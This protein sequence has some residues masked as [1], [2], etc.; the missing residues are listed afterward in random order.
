MTG[1]RT[2]RLDDWV[3]ASGLARIDAQALVRHVLGLDR[4]QQAARPEQPVG[5]E[6]LARLDRLATRLREGEPLAYVVGS[7]EFYGLEFDVTPDV[8]IPRPET[9]L[10]VDLAIERLDALPHDRAARALDLGT[11]SGAIAI[12]LAVQRPAL[13]VWAVD[14]SA[15]ALA[16]AKTNALRLLDPARP[17]GP[18]RFVQSRWFDAL[19]RPGSGCPR[20]DCIASN[21]PYVA[22]HDPHLQALRF[23]PALALVGA[24]PNADGL[25]DI[26]HIVGQAAR[27]LVPGGWLLLEHGHDQAA[28]VR[29]AL[30]AAGYAAVRSHRDLAGIERVSVG[31]TPAAAEESPASGKARR[32]P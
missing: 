13:E 9:E 15:A 32:G 24:D 19:D 21:P 1:D 25:G 31:R 17:G 11:G 22:A 12:A 2:V 20:F 5:G 7:R 4:A 18:I 10:L 28:A 29:A 3:R 27:F 16:V 30:Q 23:E 6:D 14:S 26:R 8:L